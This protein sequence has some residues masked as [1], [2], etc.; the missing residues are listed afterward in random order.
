MNTLVVLI[1]A[2]P[3]LGALAVATGARARGG[4]AALAVGGAG[5]LVA[6]IVLAVRV[7]H[8][9]HYQTWSG[10]VY[11]DSLGAFFAVVISSVVVLASL[12]SVAYL[13]EED[14]RGDLSSF[15]VGLY[16]VSFSLFA[17]AML[18]VFLTGNLGLL[19]ILVEASTLASV[20]LVGLEA[21]RRSLE[22]A[23]KYVII[24]SFGVTIALVATLFLFYSASALHLSSDQ[25]LTWAYL[26]AHA[27]SL[28]PAS[29]RLAFLLAVVGYGTKVG[30]A[31]MHTWLPDAHSEAPSPVSAMLSAGLLNTGMYAIIRFHAIASVALGPTYPSTTLLF[32]GFLTVFTGV[33]FMVR[34]GNY[35]RLFAYS[36]VEHM[37]IISVALGFGG[38]L[39]TYGALLQVLSHA[40]G[41]SVLFLSSGHIVLGYRTRE[42]SKVRGMLGSL[43]LAGAVLL[44][45]S[46]AVAGSPPFGVFLSELTIVRAGFAGSAVTGPV[47]AGFLV[48]LLVV[49]FV[50]LVV[51]AISMVSGE[52]PPAGALVPYPRRAR[53]LLAA[54]PMVAGLGALAVLGLWVP[55]A[56]NELLVHS[57]RAVL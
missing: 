25:R 15:Q 47:L 11:V 54:A 12:A 41:K 40:I 57:V 18:A 39:G 45:G 21:K 23:W 33:I 38:T 49:G 51:P 26:F 14:E 5:S 46:L 30:L 42:S 20:V 28:A 17:S 24:S 34:G 31:P 48:L 6:A 53:R 9:G 27:R 1:V 43:P 50:S 13:S 3:L 4:G 7:V 10:F 56:L 2:F 16:L 55:G 35:K 52:G 29:M 32:F 37:G 8:A 36:S 19:W 44:L 22:A